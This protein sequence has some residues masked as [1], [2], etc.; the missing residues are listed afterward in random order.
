MLVKIFTFGMKKAKTNANSIIHARFDLGKELS[1]YRPCSQVPQ[2][3][4][5]QVLPDEVASPRYSAREM[6]KT[7]MMVR[8]TVY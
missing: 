4:L 1:P 7:R 5:N 2:D 6:K 3:R 8:Y